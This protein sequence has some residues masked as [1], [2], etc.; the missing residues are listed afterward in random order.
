MDSPETDSAVPLRMVAEQ[1]DDHASYAGAAGRR[2]GGAYQSEA[3]L[4]RQLIADLVS[5]GYDRLR[6]PKG[7]V[8]IEELLLGNLRDKL[9][10]L[11]ASKLD[12]G[13]FTDDEWARLLRDH[14]LNPKHKFIDR[15]RNLRETFAFVLDSG[16]SP[17]LIL[18]SIDPNDNSYQVASQVENASGHHENRYDVTVLVNGLPLVHIELKRRGISIQE[19]FKQI[20]RYRRDSFWASTDATRA[21]LYSWVQLFVGSN[22]TTTRYWSNTVKE[23]SRKNEAGED[24]KRT[25]TPGFEFTSRWAHKD[26]RRIH[27]LGEFARTFM[28][29]RRLG[30]MLYDYCIID[31]RD[32]MKVLRPYQVYAV[33]SA[34]ERARQRDPKILGT[35][36]AGGYI[37]HT[38]GSG[39]TLTS[40]VL[41]RIL[42]REQ[43]GNSKVLFVVDRQD[44]DYQTKREFNTF[45]PDSV[46]GNKNTTELIEHLLDPNRKIIVT[47]I[48]KLAA[49][50]KRAKKDKRVATALGAVTGEEVVIIYDECHRSQSGFSHPSI[51]RLFPRHRIFGFTGT[52]IFAENAQSGNRIERSR[53]EAVVATTD[54]IFGACLHS[55]TIVHAIDD[56]NVLKFKIDTQEVGGND[57]HQYEHPERVRAIVRHVAH[58]HDRLT[59]RRSF[60][61][62]FAAPSVR[63][64]DAYYKAFRAY[65]V[66][67]EEMRAAARAEGDR[68]ALVAIPRPLRIATVYTYGANT[69]REQSGDLYS[70]DD[71]DLD[72]A[73]AMSPS[74]R[75]SLAAAL[76]DYNRSYGTNFMLRDFATYKDDIA[77]RMKSHKGRAGDVP[78]EI[79]LLIV[80]NMFLTGFDAPTLN[81]LYLDKDLRMHGLIQALSRT[82]RIVNTQKAHGEIVCYRDLRDEVD[83]A[84]RLFGQEQAGQI[85]LLPG[86][87]E[88]LL[89]VSAAIDK[90]ENLGSPHEVLDL[91]R[92]SEKKAFVKAWTEYLRARNIIRTF[93]AYET[94]PVGEAKLAD[95]DVQDYSSVY[96]DLHEQFA[97][98]GN[99]GGDDAEDE[100]DADDEG[101]VFDITLLKTIEVNIDY[102]LELIG[103][104]VNVGGEDEDESAR[105]RA[106][107]ER[108]I[109]A[110]ATLREKRQLIGDFIDELLA[111]GSGESDSIYQVFQTFVRGRGQKRIRQ[112]A[113]G[114]GLDAGKTVEFLETKLAQ[115]EFVVTGQD[116][117]RLKSPSTKVGFGA[118]R[119]AWKV[120]VER[121]L[122]RAYN[123][124][125]GI[126]EVM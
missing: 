68:A 49:L 5:Q 74:D 88:C 47:T 42:A 52:P 30:R 126:V 99:F 23:L 117:T 64:A 79:D 85:V 15:A 62:L 38:T 98:K 80:V 54:A 58:N 40:F 100:G 91:K 93:S 87:D 17:N 102:I 44:L 51:K 65:N 75:E 20:N 2:S 119:D 57:P 123:E 121:G 89:A 55:Y 103:E 106:D 120:E 73:D 29:R 7:A 77:R 111:S 1:A 37:W 21:G 97:K 31:T 45:A 32:D 114:L 48:Q 4:E 110:S 95:R 8:A 72:R 16:R 14:L 18:L 11:N 13:Q 9:E 118:A 112:M 84:L 50:V 78:F 6:L 27:E 28:D 115:Q 25:K 94:E 33:E 90:V 81:T 107:I 39:K 105:I 76:S 125:V 60:N 46:D 104:L 108:H 124:L 92:E 109:G 66:E 67:L 61:A 53:G 70:I 26:N 56:Q 59:H 12:G 116:V 34:L 122:E 63:M 69:E 3:E 83:E 71:E 113:E 86:Y 43:G 24:V 10:R 41:A 19:A 35:L 101:V 96:H 36:N 82:N 22:G